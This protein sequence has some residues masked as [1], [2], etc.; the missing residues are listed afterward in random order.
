[1]GDGGAKL[2]QRLI[3]CRKLLRLRC[4]RGVQVRGRVRGGGFGDDAPRGGGTCGRRRFAE[5]LQRLRSQFRRREVRHGGLD[6]RFSGLGGR[7]GGAAV[8]RGGLGGEFS[9]GRLGPRIAGFGAKIGD[10]RVD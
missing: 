2:V 8:D 3:Q 9:A 7:L 1:I 10:G 4:E 5:R 6:G